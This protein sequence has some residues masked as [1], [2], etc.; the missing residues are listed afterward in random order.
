MFGSTEE[1]N[2]V[3]KEHYIQRLRKNV[4]VLVG[5]S[6]L[7]GNPINF[8]KTISTGVDD[9]WHKPADGFV[10]GPLEG[11]LGI[12][13]GTGSLV[14]HTVSGT[15]GAT[16]KVFSSISKGLLTITDDKEYINKRD[17]TAIRKKP[18]NVF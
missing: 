10:K 8:Y 12:I 2:F 6:S 16:S 3:M 15:F 1:I 9:F 14:Q 13:K 7:L 18:K 5:S 11:G 17:E 4:M